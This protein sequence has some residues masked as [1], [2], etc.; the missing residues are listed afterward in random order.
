METMPKEFC[1]YT[2][3]LVTP[4]KVGQNSV[5]LNKSAGENKIG[6]ILGNLRKM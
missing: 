3:V 2:V 1:P 4:K 5:L 6:Q